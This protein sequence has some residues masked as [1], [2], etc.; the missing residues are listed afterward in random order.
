MNENHLAM[1]ATVATL[2]KKGFRWSAQDEESVYL[3]RKR[4]CQHVM[5]QVDCFDGEDVT[6][7]GMTLEDYIEWLKNF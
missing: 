6:V 1:K 2:E 5:A 4:G 3:S 7:N